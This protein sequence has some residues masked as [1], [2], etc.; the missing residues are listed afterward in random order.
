MRPKLET[1]MPREKY[2][3]LLETYKGQIKPEILRG[4]KEA[5]EYVVL[6]EDKHLHPVWIKLPS[7]P[8]LHEI[9]GWGLPASEQK[10]KRPVM[11]KKLQNLQD[12]DTLTV[13]EI[14]EELDTNQM[15]YRDEITWIRTQIDRIFNG[16]WCYIN[17]KPTYLD[18]WHYGYLTFWS[19]QDGGK[20]EYRDRNRKF[21]HAL[22]YAYTTTLT[23]KYEYDEE[24]V[25][26]KH[27][28][29][30]YLDPERRIPEMVN[31]GRRVFCGI[32]YP[33]HRRDGASNQCLCA[34]YFE[35]IYT[36]G[37]NSA[38]ISSS[39]DHALDTLFLEITV[40]AWQKMPFFFKPI[41]KSNENPGTSLDFFATKK[42]S[43]GKTS[44]QLG[45]RILVSSTANASKLDGKKVFFLLADE[46][47]KTIE[48]NVYERHQI[49][50]ECVA[51]GAGMVIGGFIMM[52]STVGEMEG[53]GGANYK[54]LCYDSFWDQ[55]SENGQTTTGLM[56]IYM[57][58]HEGLEGF[59]DEFGESIVDEPTPRQAQTNNTQIGAKRYLKNRKQMFL[60]QKKMDKYNEEC[61]LFPES[62]S[63]CFRT[64]DGDTGFNT[65]LVNE[66]IEE[67][68]SRTKTRTG[69][70]RW[71]GDIPDTNVFW[72]DDP[73]GRWEISMVLDEQLTNRKI[74]KYVDGEHHYYPVD[75]LF[76][77][78]ADAFK[79]DKPKGK[80]KSDG[81]GAVFYDYDERLDKDKPIDM[82]RSYKFVVSYL[83]RTSKTDTFAEDMLMM[84]IYWGAKMNPEL[85]VNV[86]WPHFNRRGYGGYL[87]YE[88]DPA[89]NKKSV[90]PGF[91]AKGNKPK[92][93][94]MNRDYIED[95]AM[96]CDHLDILQQWKDI[97]GITEMTDYD[98]IPCVGGCLMA[99]KGPGIINEFK[100]KEQEAKH[101][102]KDV[103]PMRK[104]A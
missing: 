29:I 75:T 65:K 34:M 15:R 6:N 58:S 28:R 92:I 85:D 36:M 37:R 95:H 27:G 78:S 8:P 9:E 76:I 2:D 55:R 71:E 45:S 21:F 33:K 3:E 87:Y 57:P 101:D 83:Y 84:C 48:D 69:N 42:V 56:T 53:S 31:T 70:Y 94:N 41:T 50:K 100:K 1:Q 47:G 99:A 90:S 35:A 24:D 74:K 86:I 103:Y 16:Y 54:E 11:P 68:G 12:S 89:T 43:K 44:D 32:S 18:G 20:P 80:R 22:R 72:E 10:F 4:Y 39:G 97:N 91:N 51:Q 64:M 63:E 30:V 98:L 81:G 17:G 61:R 13:Q 46:G 38:I 77:A 19:F 66:R 59:V 96:R 25:D 60:D 67:I 7:P 102:I 23:I 93:F 40:P 49:L 73:K 79:Y 52:P 62:F 14:W 5:D 88:I 104:Y 26:K 82:W